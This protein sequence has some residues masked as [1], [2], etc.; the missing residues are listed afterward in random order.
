MKNEQF[1]LQVIVGRCPSKSNCYKV[2][3]LGKHASLAKTKVLTDYEKSFYLQ[4]NK[5]RNVNI[6]GLFEMELRVFNESNRADLDNALKIILDCLQKVKAI[7]N[8]NNCIK[9]IAEKF[10]DKNNP[11]I[12]FRLI[13]LQ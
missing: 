11:R 4:C 5:Y 1:D 7:K 3:K 12:E 8:D 9:L 13:K 6:T 2:I 10:I